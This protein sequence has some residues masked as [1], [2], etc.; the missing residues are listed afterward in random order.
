MIKIIWLL[1][2]VYFM[3]RLVKKLM[4]SMKEMQSEEDLDAGD[5][6]VDVEAE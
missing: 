3:S 1:A 6:I 5:A 4:S 2:T